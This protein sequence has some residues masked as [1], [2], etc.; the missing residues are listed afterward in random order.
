MKQYLIAAAVA[1]MI[2]PA[3]HALT[4]DET[5]VEDVGFGPTELNATL[6]FDGYTGS[7]TVTEV[8]LGFRGVIDSDISIF[9]LS[10]SS[11]NFSAETVS[12]F[13][14]SSPAGSSDFDVA[15]GTGPQPIA[16]GGNASFNVSGSNTGSQTVSGA[17][18]T[19]FLSPFTVDLETDTFI[20]ISGGGGQ[21]LGG[22]NTEAFG[23][24]TVEYVIDD[25]VTIIPLPASGIL[26]FAALGSFFAF[27]RYKT[28]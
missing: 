9:N 14:F 3:A 20:R 22:Q 19:P 15:A 24:V 6:N 18:I 26:M 2:A 13:S 21:V 7:G 8:R 16:G 27:R 25:P 4:V 5:Q 10:G 1:T 17:G 11:Q 12:A 23:E 28:V